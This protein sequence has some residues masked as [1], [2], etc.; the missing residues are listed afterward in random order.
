M[1]TLAPLRRRELRLHGRDAI[2]LWDAQDPHTLTIASG[3]SDAQLEASERRRLPLSPE[4]ALRRQLAAW[5]D[6]LDGGP[7]PRS[8]LAHGIEV[9]E[10]IDA[11]RRLGAA[12]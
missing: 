8:D 7:P 4:P 1:K 2:A 6:W 3:D 11:V 5:L 9:I 10:R 12:A